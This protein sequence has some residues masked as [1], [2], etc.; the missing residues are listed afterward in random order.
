[1][2]TFLRSATTGDERDR[3]DTKAG[4]RILDKGRLRCLE[5]RQ[6]DH[7]QAGL[8]WQAPVGPGR[9]TNGYTRGEPSCPSRGPGGGPVTAHRTSR[10]PA[11]KQRCQTC[12]YMRTGRD[13]WYECHRRE[14]RIAIRRECDDQARA[15]RG[16]LDGL[17]QHQS[18][19]RRMRPMGSIATL[20]PPALM[21]EPAVGRN[22]DVPSASLAFAKTIC[23]E[24]HTPCTI[25]RPLRSPSG[26]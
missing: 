19:A 7:L 23:P 11:G 2:V 9:R 15:W 20:R 1:M 24:A 26:K 22:T 18:S 3:T 16:D 25:Q 14:P 21:M 6:D 10:E 12:R 17:A 5:P 4:F 8:G 13:G